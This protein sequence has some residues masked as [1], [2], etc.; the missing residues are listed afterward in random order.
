[1]KTAYNIAKYD[2]IYHIDIAG[3]NHRDIVTHA[4]VLLPEG[5][6][7]YDSDKLRQLSYFMANGSRSLYY[8]ISS[9]KLEGKNLYHLYNREIKNLI[10]EYKEDN[11]RVKKP[12]P[13]YR[14]VLL[15]NLNNVNETF[16]TQPAFVAYLCKKHHLNVN[17]PSDWI[18]NLLEVDWAKQENVDS[19]ADEN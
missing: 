13:A 14:E 10:Y 12:F 4:R 11:L 15:E 19:I 2:F 9:G 17:L 6:E 16:W 1:M 7:N 5:W 8:L 3:L 18:R